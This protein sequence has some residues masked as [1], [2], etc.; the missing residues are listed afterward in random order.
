MLIG[1]G[2]DIVY[3]PRIENIWKKY[4]EKFLTRVYSEQEII[5]SYKYSDYQMQ[6]RYF[7]KRFAAKEALVKALGIGFYG[8]NMK[9]IEISNDKNGKPNIT[10]KN[11][12]P[13]LLS[14]NDIIQVSLSDDG[15]YAIAYV[16]ILQSKELSILDTNIS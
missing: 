12:V 5:N 13:N 3:I 1:N 4:K 8:I 2:V 7:A 16:I 10:V 9:D 15:D 11:N 6:V 14:K